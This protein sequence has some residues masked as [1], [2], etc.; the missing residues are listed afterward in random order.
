MHL[1]FNVMELARI[2]LN[3]GRYLKSANHDLILQ[4][5]VMMSS[6]VHVMECV[7]HDTLVV[8]MHFVCVVAMMI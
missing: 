3:L 6:L 2:E 4:P 5:C 8:C 7:M 1:N